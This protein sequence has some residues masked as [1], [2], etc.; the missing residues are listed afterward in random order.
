MVADAGSERTDATLDGATL[1]SVF[2]FDVFLFVPFGEGTELFPAQ[3][4]KNEVTAVYIKISEGYDP[5]DVKSAIEQKLASNHHVTLDNKDFTVVTS[6]FIRKT[7]GTI[8]DTLSKLLFAITAVATV[9]GGIG[10][11][12]T[13]FMAVLERVR[14][15]GILKSIGASNQDIQLI[16]LTESAFIGLIGGIIGFL[17]AIAILLIGHEFGLPYLIRIRWVIFVFVFSSFVGIIAGFIPAR[18][19]ANLDPVEALRFE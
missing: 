16:F 3:L 8:L 10:I 9:V 1:N 11:T 13:M 7:V 19:A 15:I 2:A 6:D 18:Q 14:E 5:Q 12:N 17:I 4:A